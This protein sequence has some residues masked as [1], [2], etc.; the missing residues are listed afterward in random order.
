VD[1]E[2][3]H[4]GRRVVGWGREEPM[5]HRGVRGRVV[6]GNLDLMLA[7]LG[8]LLSLALLSLRLLADQ[9][10]LVVIPVSTGTACLLYLV[11]RREGTPSRRVAGLGLPTLP[12]WVAGHLP[13]VVLAA[14]GTLVV[15]IEAAGHRT[16]PIYLLTGGIG[17]LLLV[18]ALLGG[19]ERLSPGLV[20]VQILVA[21]VV[22]RLSAL[23]A[24]PGFVGVD[25]WT[26]VPVFVERV[27]DTG[28][29]SGMGETKYVLAP[30]YHA[31]GSIGSLVFGSGRAGVYLTV[32]VLVPLAALFV[33]ATARLFVPA[34]WALAA[35][36]LYAFADQFVRW[37]MHVIPTS[38]GLVFFLATAFL[39]TATFL[40]DEGW[41]PLALLAFGLAVVFTHQVS[42]AITLVFLGVAATVGVLQALLGGGRWRTGIS[43]AGAFLL[44]LTVTVAVW[45]VTPW[46]G[47]RT[48]L[49][50]ILDNI[51]ETIGQAGFLNLAGDGAA[52]GGAGSA[53]LFAQVQ[54]YVELF[55]FSLLLTVA[56]LG[57]L[58]MLEWRESIGATLTLIV[59]AAVMFVVVFGFS[60]F[61]YRTFLP[62]R[63]VAFLYAP[64]VVLG[65][66]GLYHASR[67]AATGVFLALVVVLTL[68]YPT[69]M[70]VAEKAT[71]DS[72]AFDEEYPRFAYTEAE[73]AAVESMGQIRPASVE[74]S[75]R[76]DHPYYTTFEPLGGYEADDFVVGT[77]GPVES[78]SVVF[79]EYQTGSP[80][81]FG[82][83]ENV[84]NADA[85][86]PI[87]EATVCPARRDAVYANDDVR[88]CTAT[89]VTGVSGE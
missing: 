17:S 73:I 5:S 16:I 22:I 82:I 32:G 52:V 39:T 87:T 42:T 20:L 57:G 29:L 78:H 15:A 70:A 30:F 34:R 81:A 85:V 71:L 86:L 74:A 7:K 58:A 50:G 51:T 89:E 24:T 2:D 68:G 26:H 54:P 46:T 88:V 83:A 31:I 79:R 28:S 61:G 84:T 12:G 80:V 62:G 40:R 67:H 36:V 13:A 25:V 65:A 21:A 35:T 10:L 48:F 38:L 33:Y 76:S 19:E 14:L 64:M 60:L 53:G 27:V 6:G 45:A 69:T 56:V 63:W 9:V 55:G 59:A 75:I 47:E 37:G 4:K 44:T 49:W 8:L 1:A 18:Q 43:L 23:F 3:G 66:A 77:D 41:I 11:S 72:P